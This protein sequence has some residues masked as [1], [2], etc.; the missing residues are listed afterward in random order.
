MLLKDILS[1]LIGHPKNDD[2]SNVRIRRE[3]VLNMSADEARESLMQY[4]A[5]SDVFQSVEELS[6]DGRLD[7]LPPNMRTLLQRFRYIRRRGSEIIVSRD[8]IKE[9]DGIYDGFILIGEDLDGAIVLVRPHEEPIYIF[10][11][12]ERTE[13]LGTAL[14]P[15]V[16]HWL[17]D[18]FTPA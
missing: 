18:S 16:Y 9:M 5:S 17:L 10:D 13:E 14:Y 4:L 11:G 15:T 2:H 12:E 3:T 1:A 6:N 8:L 7:A